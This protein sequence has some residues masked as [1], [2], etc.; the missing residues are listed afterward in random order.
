MTMSVVHSDADRGHRLARR[1][2]FGLVG[3]ARWSGMSITGMSDDERQ[4][5]PEMA[6]DTT[7]MWDVLLIEPDPPMAAAVAEHLRADDWRVEVVHDLAAA[8]AAAG[9]ATRLVV[10]LGP[11]LAGRQEAFDAARRQLPERAIVFFDASWAR[12]LREQCAVGVPDEP[13]VERAPAPPQDAVFQLRLWP[14]LAVLRANAAFGALFGLP[15]HP[16]PAAPAALFDAIDPTDLKRVEM[17]LQR[18]VGGQASVRFRMRDRVAVPHEIDLSLVALP[19]DH[20]QGVRLMAVARQVDPEIMLLAFDR[21]ANAAA[22]FG[23]Q[24]ERRP[25]GGPGVAVA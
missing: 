13:P 24:N 6:K 16:N 2:R 17:A 18:A 7:E 14:R 5:G 1:N 21:L 11:S 23:D 25:S 4:T 22:G 12:R 9:D 3:S 20:D 8:V 10:V 15:G 19:A